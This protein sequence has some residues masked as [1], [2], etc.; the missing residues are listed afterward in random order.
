MDPANTA[1]FSEKVIEAIRR[2]IREELDKNQKGQ[3]QGWVRL[4]DFWGCNPHEILNPVANTK[5]N[6][7]LGGQDHL[8]LNQVM[9]EI[10]LFFS[11]VGSLRKDLGIADHVILKASQMLAKSLNIDVSSLIPPVERMD[12][13]STCWAG[14]A[15]GAREIHNDRRS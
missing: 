3:A 10:Q 15:F 9:A 11:T 6:G 5:S 8:A 7:L 2:L 4:E 13:E 12:Q 14:Q 1:Y